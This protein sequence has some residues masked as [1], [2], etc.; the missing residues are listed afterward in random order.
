MNEPR[1]LAKRMEESG[2]NPVTYNSF[3]RAL[4]EAKRLDDAQS[5]LVRCTVMN[6]KLDVGYQLG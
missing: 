5:Q 2:F 4:S 6:K 3:I 1:A